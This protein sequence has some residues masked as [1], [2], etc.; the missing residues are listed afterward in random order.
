MKKVLVIDSGSGGV[1]VLAHSIKQNVSGDFLYYADTK[2]APY[3][4]KTNKQLK[5]IL[6]SILEEI[7]PFFCFD[8]VLIACNTMTT[9]AIEYVRKKYENI[10]FIGTEPAI[11]PAT[12][13]FKEEEV[14]VMATERTLKNLNLEGLHIY[15]LPKIIDE[16]LFEVHKIKP[17]VEKE[18]CAYKDKKAIVLGCTH[19][20]TLKNLIKEILPDVTLF[21]SQE[22]V[23]K[24]LKLFCGEGDFSVQFMSSDKDPSVFAVYFYNQLFS[25]K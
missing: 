15:N 14:F 21:D 7:R 13:R 10:I 19:F 16:N 1:N 18:L 11:K 4:N 9:A 5:K 8:I 22:G 24:R 3:G 20:M 6:V 25:N 2:N 23:S 12:A 17:Y